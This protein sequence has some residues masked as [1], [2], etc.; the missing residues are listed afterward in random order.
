MNRNMGKP[1]FNKLKSF[2]Q[3]QD[4]IQQANLGK[5]EI[6][7]ESYLRSE[8]ILGTQDSIVF[9]IQENVSQA[10]IAVRRTERR[11]KQSDTFTVTAIGLFIARCP[12][13]VNGANSGFAIPRTFPNPQVFTGVT[14]VTEANE[15]MKIYNGLMQIQRDQTKYFEALAMWEHY[16]VTEAQQ[17]VALST[18]ATTGLYQR[19]GQF[20]ANQGFRKIQPTFNIVGTKKCEISIKLPDSAVMAS[21][22]VG[23]DNVA[24]LILKGLVKQ[25]R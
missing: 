12:A 11:L 10:G 5:D 23:Q 4:L 24:I 13:I 1:N 21:Q 19:D 3:Q 15:L 8:T 20:N 6:M 25:R 22:T 17:G 9:D 7:V 14:T 18:V 2:T 16:C